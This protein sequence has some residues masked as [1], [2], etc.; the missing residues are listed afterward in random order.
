MRDDF[1]DGENYMKLNGDLVWVPES[2]DLRP[3][4]DTLRWH[5]ENIFKG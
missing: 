5:N 1:N 2:A 4:P 3:D